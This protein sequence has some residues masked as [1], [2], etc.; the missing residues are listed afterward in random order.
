MR[1]KL[2]YSLIVVLALSGCSQSVNGSSSGG[3]EKVVE[4]NPTK[5]LDLKEKTFQTNVNLIN[6]LNG[7]AL[8][9]ISP[10]EYKDE[11]KIKAFVKELAKKVDQPMV[12][13]KLDGKGGLTKGQ[14]RIVLNEEKAVEQLKG[15]KAFDK[16]IELPIEETAP[17]VSAEAVKGI[18][19]TVIGTYK[20]TF[21]SGVKGRS[22]NIALS[23]GDINNY[24]LGPG[25]RFYFNLITGPRT[26]ERGYQKAMEI[27]NK[28]FVEGYGG[29][30]CQTSSTLYNAVVNAGLEIIE[31]HNHSRN[32]GYVPVGKDATVAYGVKDFKFANNKP[33]PVMVRA[34][35]EN[36]SL[37]IQITAAPQAVKS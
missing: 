21:D 29:G 34:I 26:P 6:K 36:G 30:I 10:A 19:D 32:I 3:A 13:V 20:T 37:T 23:S 18:G 4:A 28:E 35:V 27:V 22:A 16:R 14:N 2:L 1:G 25:D 8:A 11:A 33:Y 9:T 15:I 12:P 5:L 31:V 7:E 24:I 17:N